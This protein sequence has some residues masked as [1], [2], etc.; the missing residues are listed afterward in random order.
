ML[1]TV[2]LHWTCGLCDETVTAYGYMKLNDQGMPYGDIIKNDLGRART[3]HLTYRHQGED[4]S[5]AGRIKPHGSPTAPYTTV[6]PG[7]EVSWKCMLCDRGIVTYGCNQTN[8][9]K[10][11]RQR[12]IKDHPKLP[13]ED[14]KW[15]I[16]SAAI[17]E[18]WARTRGNTAKRPLRK[19]GGKHMGGNMIRAAKRAARINR[20][21]TKYGVPSRC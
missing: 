6:Q 14:R 16:R 2:K 21:I 8:R 1:K 20:L 17:S 18:S 10:L 13:I 11:I 9:S 19:E 7:Q 15:L 12:Y 4:K 5:K 3:N